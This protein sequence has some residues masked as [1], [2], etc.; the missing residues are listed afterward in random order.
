MSISYSSASLKEAEESLAKLLGDPSFALKEAENDKEDSPFAGNGIPALTRTLDVTFNCSG[1][2]SPQSDDRTLKFTPAEDWTISNYSNGEIHQ[3][4]KITMYMRLKF[5]NISVQ[6]TLGEDGGKVVATVSLNNKTVALAGDAIN[7]FLNP[8]EAGELISKEES[9]NTVYTLTL[10]GK[11]QEELNSALA[12]VSPHT[13]YSITPSARSGF[14]K[15]EVGFTYYNDFGSKFGVTDGK[16]IQHTVII[17]GYSISGSNLGNSS[18]IKAAEN[19]LSATGVA[20]KFT[21]GAWMLI[22]G[23][24]CCVLLGAGI[25]F[26]KRKELAGKLQ[27]RKTRQTA[28]QQTPPLYETHAQ[29]TQAVSPREAAQTNHDATEGETIS[30]NQSIQTDPSLFSAPETHTS[31]PTQKNPSASLAQEDEWSEGDIS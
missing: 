6:S 31:S 8:Q 29:E 12:K 10:T 22:L 1:L 15:K 4:G 7:A 21:L 14:F 16:D 30:E 18:I 11:S 2:C 17:D 13:T 3:S 19:P 26:W 23:I 27:T 5:S 25:L 24:I 20:S 28:L 9:E